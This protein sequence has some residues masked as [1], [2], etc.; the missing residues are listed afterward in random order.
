MASG[1]DVAPLID[2]LR[3]SLRNDRRYHANIG[4]VFTGDG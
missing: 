4:T 3:D 2:A 1:G